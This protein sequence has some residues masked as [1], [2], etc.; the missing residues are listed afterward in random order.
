MKKILILALKGYRRYISPYTIRSCRHVPSCSEYAVEA[1]ERFGIL[2]G[3]ARAVW[4]ILK[5]NPFVRG[6]YDPVVKNKG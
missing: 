5:C 1:V 4:R 3:S 2:K 6:G